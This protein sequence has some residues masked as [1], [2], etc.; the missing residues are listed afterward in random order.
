MIHLLKGEV[1]R[2]KTANGVFRLKMLSLV[3]LY[4]DIADRKLANDKFWRKRKWVFNNHIARMLDMYGIRIRDE[5][6]IPGMTEVKT[7]SRL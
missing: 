1:K 3:Y 6:Y 2:N 5:Y 4:K 7:V